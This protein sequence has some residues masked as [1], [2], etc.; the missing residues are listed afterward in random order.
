MILKQLIFYFYLDA[1]SKTALLDKHTDIQ[2]D[3]EY[4]L[5]HSPIEE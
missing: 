2:K 3:V 5:F 4:S 1:M